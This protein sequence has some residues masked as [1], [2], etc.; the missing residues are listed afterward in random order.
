MQKA[1]PARVAYSYERVSSGAQVQGGGLTRQADDAAAWCVRN[2]YELDATLDLTDAGRS[3]YKGEH[4]SKGALGRFLALAQQGQLGSNPTLLIEAV[5]RLSRQEPLDALQSTFFALV[6]AG[7]EIV[8]LEDQRHYNRES[9]AGDALILLVLKC[10]A[11]HDYSKRLSRRL[12]AHWD[13][14][15]EGFRDGSRIHR[16]GRGGRKPHWLELDEAG[17][18]WIVND[19]AKD[20]QLLFDLL[21]VQGLKLTAE[22]LNAQ[23]I[24]G[25]AGKP[26]GAD[27]VRKMAI[28]PAAMGTLRLGQGAH[29]AGKTALSRWKRRKAEAEKTGKRFT[30][31]EPTVPPVELIE[32]FYPAVIEREQFER[33]GRLIASR[34]HSPVAAA[35]RGA[36]CGHSFL[37]G[38]AKCHEG[39]FMGATL[40]RPQRAAPR[41]Y[42]RCR[43]R[44]DGRKCSCGGKGWLLPEL[45]QHIVA[46]LQLHLLNKAALPGEDRGAE[47]AA[48]SARLK[49]A[50]AQLAEAKQGATNAQEKLEHAIDHGTADTVANISAVLE[51]RR[52]ALRSAQASVG[53]L[54]DEVKRVESRC[55]PVD[56]LGDAAGMAL[57]KAIYEE[58][59]SQKDRQR[60]N[61]VL[62]AAELEVVLDSS[63]PEKPMVGMRFGSTAEM[64]WVEWNPAMV[65]ISLS[66]GGT[67]LQ[68]GAAGGHRQ[69]AASGYSWAVPDDGMED[70]ASRDEYAADP[71]PDQDY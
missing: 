62:K 17:E 7:V 11:A 8:D 34:R 5:D 59:E 16:G 40:S 51:K 69:Y 45:H 55:N 63:D 20:L 1:A 13:Q 27:A 67:E 26:W 10:R 60:L 3:A 30:E 61:D 64:Q 57:L 24:P 21:E 46:R 47:L 32:G 18:R 23:G 14:T 53:A 9:L 4:L 36:G 22:Q 71:F 48:A 37:Q 38:L 49:A 65:R 28:N 42:L 35:N 19:R 29:V 52:A 70:P 54:Q 68:Q 2:G 58:T 56:Q 44:L 31:A 15:R 12:E 41:Y 6:N 39:G 33:I 66:L 50:Q 25:P 43:R